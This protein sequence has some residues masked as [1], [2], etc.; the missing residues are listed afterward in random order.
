MKKPII[1]AV[2]PV[3]KNSERLKNKNFLKFYKG[4]SLL[5]IKIQQLK[6]IKYIDRIVVSSDSKIAEKIAKKN[7]V[8]FH[9]REKF[10]AS[11]KCSGSDFFENLAQSIECDY[12]GYFPC[13]SP[14]IKKDTY[15]NF[16]KNFLKNRKSFDSFNS[17]TVLKKF[18]WKGKKTIN[19]KISNAPN[20]Q[21]L[22][23]DF[24]TITFGLNIISRKKM[25]KY[26]NIVGKK[27]QFFLISK[28]ES[29]DIDDAVDFDMIK[30]IYPKFF[31]SEKKIR[32]N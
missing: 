18:L 1:A 24:Y 22:P 2:V 26:K 11:S 30:S 14:I 8:F 5:E 12:L 21:N 29:S 13:T 6:K 32:S 3:R 20:S 31:I 25:I 16:L 9:K 27:P 10:F 17:V 4:K 15:L 7:G 28:I 19:Y 23:D